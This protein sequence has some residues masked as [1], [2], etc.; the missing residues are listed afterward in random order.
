MPGAKSNVT[1]PPPGSG[2]D[3]LLI[4]CNSKLSHHFV[5][6]FTSSWIGGGAME[7]LAYSLIGQEPAFEEDDALG[8][9]SRAFTL[10]ESELGVPLYLDAEELASGVISKKGMVTYLCLVRNAV[11]AL[12]P[13]DADLAAAVLSPIGSPDKLFSPGAGSSPGLVSMASRSPDR[14][15]QS[16]IEPEEILKMG[17][18]KLKKWLVIQGCDPAEVSKCM[19]YE[20]LIEIA[21]LHGFLEVPKDPQ[22]PKLYGGHLD[23]VVEYR[24]KRTAELLAGKHP[25]NKIEKLHVRQTKPIEK[26]TYLSQGGTDYH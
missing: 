1:K 15:A 5:T 6:D 19:G 2:L 4:W 8:R 17:Y 23:T 10:L 26:L 3:G 13:S 20:E 7:A 16:D 11:K 18:M 21:A 14:L 12:E 25:S 24:D 22:V 9:F